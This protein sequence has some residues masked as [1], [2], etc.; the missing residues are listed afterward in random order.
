MMEEQGH[1]KQARRI[2]IDYLEKYSLYTRRIMERLKFIPRRGFI[3]IDAPFHMKIN[4]SLYSEN[5]NKIRAIKPN[6]IVLVPTGRFF[7]KSKKLRPNPFKD[8]L[9]KEKHL[10]TLIVTNDGI[11]KVH[12]NMVTDL[13]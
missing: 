12:K 1:H 9:I 4:A 2:Y 5:N 8:I 13:Y 3:K 11:L 10:L 6:E 7:L